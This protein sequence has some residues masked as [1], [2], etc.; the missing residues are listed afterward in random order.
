MKIVLA[1]GSPRRRELLE[2]IGVKFAVAPPDVDETQHSGEDPISYVARVSQDKANAAAADAHDN[3]VL[4]IAA[5]TTV[6]IDGVAMAKPADDNEARAMLRSLSGRTHAVHTG[7][8]VRRGIRSETEVCTTE[9]TMAK[10][11]DEVINWYIGTGDPFDKAG[12][13]GLQTAGAVLVES[14]SGNVSNVVGLPLPN[15]IAMC[16]R[17]GAPLLP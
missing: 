11:S 1:S 17:L 9:V 5:D 8:T 2:S 7:I 4:V 10:L 6:E 14:V 15:L 13:Y 3:H 12:G 16:A